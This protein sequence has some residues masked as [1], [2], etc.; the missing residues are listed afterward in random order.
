MPNY[1]LTLQYDGTGYKG[2]QKQPGLP[3]V[4]GTL[5]EAL[6][7]VA[8]LDSPIYA[9]GRTDA[10]VHARGQV[11]NFFG[12]LKPSLERFPAALNAFLTPDIVVRECE[13][14]EEGFNARRSA[15]A[16]EYAYY[17]FR[18]GY[19][20]PFRRRYTYHFPGDLSADA[21]GDALGTVVGAHDFAAFARREEGK[22]S[23][24]EVYEAE[25]LQHDDELCV[26]IKANAF[27]WM[28][29]RMLCGSLLEVGRGR[30][31]VE[32]FVEVLESRDNSRSGPALPPRG[33][34]LEKVY[35]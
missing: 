21:M 11:V 25:L 8:T 24:R 22:S 13:E 32:Y 16:R 6:A 7:A 29:M 26:R 33:L 28:M 15:S 27:V 9:A 20:S 30:W 19:P 4:Q 5:E 2:W 31:S 23:V 1:K 17:V 14:A 12:T 10:G 3:T 18:G 35:Y 34:F